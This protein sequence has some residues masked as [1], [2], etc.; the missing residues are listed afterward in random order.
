[1]TG[2]AEQDGDARRPGSSSGARRS[3]A[4]G[5]TLFGACRAPPRL[6]SR[7]PCT[8]RQGHLRVGRLARGRSPRRGVHMT[9]RF[10]DPVRL[11]MSRPV[12]ELYIMKAD[13]R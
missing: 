5:P 11:G 9:E 10:V 7:L 13:R 4:Q 1:E 8:E 6:A 12:F 3:P 2:G